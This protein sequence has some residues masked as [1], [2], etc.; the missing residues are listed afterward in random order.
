MIKPDLTQQ[1]PADLGARPLRRHR[2]LGHERHRPR[3]PRRRAPRHRLRLARDRGRRGA[4]RRSAPGSPS[5]TT[6]RTSAT[7]TPSW[8]RAP[9][10][11]TTPSTSSRWRRASRCC[12]A[13]R[14][15]PGSIGGQRLVSVAG[16]HGKT[17]S[18][19]MIVTA[20]LEAGRDPSFVNGGVIQSL[21]VSAQGG[22]DDLFVVEA[23]ESD[24]SFLLY[25]TA[26]AL[27]TNVDADH[28][29]HYGSCEAFDD[30]FVRV[31][32]G[33]V[34][35]RRHL[36]RRRRCRRGSPRG[37]TARRVVT[38]G[39]APRR[40]RARDRRHLGRPGRLHD[41]HDGANRGRVQLR[42]PGRHNALNAAGAFAVLVG[43]RTHARRG[44]SRGSRP[45]AAPSAGSSCTAPSGASASTTTTPT[46]PPRSR[47]RCQAA[48]TVVGD[49]RLI[50]V[51]QPHLY[52]RTR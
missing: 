1:I 44:R 37:S 29:D 42:V 33:G 35:V 52:S 4:A 51:H 6:P 25:D 46:T 5:A 9:S 17:T 22:S 43:S 3:V 7:P 24:G 39:E 2:R 11:R 13:P 16:A 18:T 21:G 23:D 28:L 34:R 48:R 19:G 20:L 14:P 40:R 32:D 49:G 8:S 12:T 41:R 26:V 27:I 45:S 50:A 10:G 47:R 30:A 38:F 15:S 31:R 36:E